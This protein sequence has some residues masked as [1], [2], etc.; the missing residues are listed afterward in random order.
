M[1]TIEQC[2]WEDICWGE[3]HAVRDQRGEEIA[4]FLHRSHAEAFVKFLGS[5]TPE[6]MTEA[7]NVLRGGV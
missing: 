1:F 6:D 4:V 3:V 2:E 5:T 7:R